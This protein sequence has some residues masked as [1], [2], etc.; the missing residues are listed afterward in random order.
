[1]CV[2]GHMLC[3]SGG[4]LII[5]IMSFCK[6]DTNFQKAIF[7]NIAN[8]LFALNEANFWATRTILKELKTHT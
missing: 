3:F 7:A 4:D 6:A 2:N 5:F 1:M 8:C